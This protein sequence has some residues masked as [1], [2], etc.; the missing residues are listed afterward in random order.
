ML[1]QA[2][3]SPVVFLLL[4]SSALLGRFIRLRLP[5]HHR[6]RET[7]EAMQIIIGMLVTF[8]ALVLGLLTASVKT[9]Y[10]NAGHDL[11]AYA[12][13]LTQL[14]RCLRDYGSGADGARE[15]IKAYTAALIAA[16]WTSEPPPSGVRY[17]S[18]PNEQRVGPSPVLGD[19]LNRAYLEIR[20]LGPKNAFQSGVR[21]DCA[22]DFRT[23]L[24]GRKAAIEDDRLQV[25]TPFDIILVVWLMIIFAI[26]GLVAP[27]NIVS[28]IGVVLCSISVSLAIFVIGSLSHPYFI[29]FPSD[30][31]RAALASMMG[32][33]S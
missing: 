8:T 24:N 16:T 5:A 20:Q 14:D 9:A 27:R 17:P 10:D 11:Q 1:N 28:L 29:A 3:C 25:S 6:E 18:L 33:S 30:Y 15:A 13:D 32:P 7:I 31:M 22:I 12:L 26:F 2:F 21:E 4:T 19:T 23:M